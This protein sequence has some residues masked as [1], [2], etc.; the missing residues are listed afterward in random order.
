VVKGSSFQVTSGQG[1]IYAGTIGK[2]GR[3][4]WAFVNAPSRAFPKSTI[5]IVE[6]GNRPVLKAV[7]T[8]DVLV[9]MNTDNGSAAAGLKKENVERCF[10]G[11]NGARALAQ[12]GL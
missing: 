6:K 10:R 4:V 3:N 7:E 2:D 12:L 5:T 11:W 9:M 8:P 1:S